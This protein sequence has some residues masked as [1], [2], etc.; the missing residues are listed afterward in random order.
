MANIL[1][2]TDLREEIYSLDARLG[3]PSPIAG[4][5]YANI[6]ALNDCFIPFPLRVLWRLISLP[7]FEPLHQS[8]TMLIVYRAMA[9][10]RSREREEIA[11]RKAKLEGIPY[12]FPFG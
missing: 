12:F 11:C 5:K 2:S 8:Q 7:F 10:V 4:H 3:F 9:R 1:A 6:T